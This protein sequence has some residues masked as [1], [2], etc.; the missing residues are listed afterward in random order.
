MFHEAEVQSEYLG[1]VVARADLCE[2]CGVQLE[3]R[4]A[5][6][7][8]VNEFHAPRRHR[9]A[10]RAARARVSDADGKA[11]REESEQ[12]A[13]R[14]SGVWRECGGSVEGESGESGGR[15]ERNRDKLQGATFWCKGSGISDQ[16]IKVDDP[17][18]NFVQLYQVVL[19][20]QR[21]GLVVLHTSSVLDIAHATSV[22][23][24]S[25]VLGAAC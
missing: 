2:A 7:H 22:L 12:R 17:P 19:Q 9:T 11:E 6:R 21:A 16:D 8:A 18:S 23:G 15:E 20:Y 5:C 4:E 14:E 10:A 13:W 1:R 25:A 3:H 24:Q